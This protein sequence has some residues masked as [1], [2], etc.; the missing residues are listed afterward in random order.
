M[1]QGLEKEVKY[2]MMQNLFQA[3]APTHTKQ[4]KGKV[5]SGDFQ[6]VQKSKITNT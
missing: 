5:K 6:K 3:L 1:D 2:P 4:T